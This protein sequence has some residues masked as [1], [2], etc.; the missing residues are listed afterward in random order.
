MKK[1]LAALVSLAFLLGMAGSAGS[2]DGKPQAPG[3]T[4]KP[5]KAEA[6]SLPGGEQG[7]GFDDIVYAPALHQVIVPAAQTGRV[8]LIDPATWSHE[9]CAVWQGRTTSADAGDGYVFAADRTH[10][11]VKV[12]DPKLHKVVASA[13]LEMEPDIVRYVPATHEVWVT[14]EDPQKGQVE[15]LAFSAGGKVMLSHAADVK[16]AGGGGPESLS[17]DPVRSRVYTNRE[18]Q[19]VTVAIDIASRR[20]VAEWKNGTEG[21]SSGL[22]LDETEAWLFVGSGGG[23]VAVVDVAHNGRILGTL[24]V[25]KG[26]DLIGYNPILRHVYVPDP[27]EGTLAIIGVSPGG[28]PRLLGT[29][30]T[31]KGSHAAAADNRGQVWVTDPDHG[32][33]LVVKDT[34]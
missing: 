30:E 15:I 25:G 31:A 8:Y 29:V 26:T 23:G 10:S 18:D 14:E 5:V 32:R 24:E 22:A 16:V 2:D 28:E 9:S 13:T 21:S 4:E 34:L 11:S 6:V 12:I 27:K 7:I 20:I 1:S 3:Q 33:L 19:K 17:V